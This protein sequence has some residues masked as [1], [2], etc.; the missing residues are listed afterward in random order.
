MRDY[1]VPE[2]TRPVDLGCY[3]RRQHLLSSLI[4][5]LVR[6]TF[7]RRPQEVQ[8]HILVR[9]PGSS[10]RSSVENIATYREDHSR[11]EHSTRGSRR[12]MAL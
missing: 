6:H 3:L 12:D 8:I 10:F 4:T 7:V 5:I 2:L 11:R 1:M 9:L